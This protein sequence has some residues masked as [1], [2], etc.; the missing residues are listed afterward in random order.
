MEIVIVYMYNLEGTHDVTKIIYG[1]RHLCILY[2]LN[3]VAWY[4]GAHLIYC[5]YT[6]RLSESY[7]THWIYW[8]GMFISNLVFLILNFKYYEWKIW[9]PSIVTLILSGALVVMMFITKRRTAD[10]PRPDDL[11][12]DIRRRSMKK[13][14][15][16]QEFQDA[17]EQD[18]E[19]T[20]ADY[21]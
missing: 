12:S 1:Q 3:M 13:G 16:F 11:D 4:V 8:G 19:V 21:L 5:E 7:Y 6:K 17:F 15:L 18:S 9:I 14:L 2:V 20:G 10:N